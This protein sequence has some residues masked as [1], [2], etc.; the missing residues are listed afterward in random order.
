LSAK[1]KK[2]ERLATRA[3]LW[4]SRIIC[5][6]PSRQYCPISGKLMARFKDGKSRFI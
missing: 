4:E 2:S 6:F 3:M 1:V 5:T